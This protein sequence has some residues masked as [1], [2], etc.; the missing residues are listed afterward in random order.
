MVL[1]SLC[2]QLF[3]LLL[4]SVALEPAKKEKVKYFFF[5]N[6]TL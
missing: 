4:R 1:F 5:S 2:I 3:A 6:M